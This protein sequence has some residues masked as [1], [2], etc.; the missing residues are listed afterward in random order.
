MLCGRWTRNPFKRHV[1][2]GIDGLLSIRGFLG[3]DRIL[4]AHPGYLAVLG[5]RD[6]RRDTEGEN[7]DK[8]KEHRR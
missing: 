3:D 4:F 8:E 1:S 7:M 5:F 2:K 6:F